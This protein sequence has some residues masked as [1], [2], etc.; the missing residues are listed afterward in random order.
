MGLLYR[1]Q[2]LH[3][4]RAW[5]GEIPISNRYTVGIVGERFFR[6][7]KDH[8]RFWA[9]RCPRCDVVYFPPRLYCE[10]CFAHLEDW[11]EVPT[12]GRVHTFTVV[13]LDLDGNPLP[14][15]R[16]LAF[17]QIDGTDGGLVHDLGEVEPEEV[18]IG[19]CVEAVF[20]AADQRRGSITDILYFRPVGTG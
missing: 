11:V 2:H 3:E 16:I 19:M 6:E 18:C 13:H 14:Q 8:G 4:V 15:P 12:T 1:L 20:K 9:V 10:R 7:I 5:E 17:I